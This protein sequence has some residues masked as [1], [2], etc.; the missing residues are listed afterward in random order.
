MKPI[1]QN[2]CIFM[3]NKYFILFILCC[4]VL[5]LSA[6]T[7]IKTLTAD[8]LNAATDLMEIAIKGISGTNYYWFCGDKS[9]GDMGDETVWLWEP[10]DNGTHLLK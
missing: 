8:E 1:R 9:L 3:R 7:P 2:L 10:A 4:S 6:Q 5:R